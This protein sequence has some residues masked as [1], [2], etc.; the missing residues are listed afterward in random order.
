MCGQDI[1]IANNLI[2]AYFAITSI[3]RLEAQILVKCGKTQRSVTNS[4]VFLWMM[5]TGLQRKKIEGLGGAN[6]WQ[7]DKPSCT[8]FTFQSVSY[9]SNP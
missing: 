4:Y 9:A 8:L 7:L 5:I 6:I 3:D 1:T 2:T